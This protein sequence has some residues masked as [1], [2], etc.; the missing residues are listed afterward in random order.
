VACSNDSG[1]DAGPDFGAPPEVA[2]S[3]LNRNQVRLT[4]FDPKASAITADIGA[5][6]Q[7]IDLGQDNQCH[8]G[9]PSCPPM[10]AAAGVDLTSGEPLATQSLFRVE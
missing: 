10:F 9:G 5:L 2:C 4:G 1:G 3:N 6:F 7:G 8:S